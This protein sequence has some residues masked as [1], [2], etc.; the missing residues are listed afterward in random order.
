VTPEQI[1]RTIEF[2]LNN[3]AA[4]DAQLAE[5]RIAVQETASSVKSVSDSVKKLSETVEDLSETSAQLIENSNSMLTEFRG[6]FRAL[7]D[8]AEQTNASVR[9]DCRGGGLN[10]E[11][12]GFGRA[13]LGSS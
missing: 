7:I 8:L 1:E 5:L 10:H 3:Q 13:S 4:H 11:T 12:N 2:L 6:G 9:L